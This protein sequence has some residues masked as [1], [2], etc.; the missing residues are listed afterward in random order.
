M[1]TVGK[2]VRSRRVD[3]ASALM[4]AGVLLLGL[5][6]VFAY[7]F[8][9]SYPGVDYDNR[10]NVLA[11]DNACQTNPDWCAVR[12]NLQ[13]GDQLIA[14]GDLTHQ[15]YQKD[16]TRVP[17]AGYGPGDTV[18]IVF[19]RDGIVQYTRWQ[20][21]GPTG[22]V[23]LYRLLNSL[24]FFLP[25]WLA[26]TAV[27]LFLR[28][29]DTRWW[30]LIAF[31]YVTAL[32]LT[33]GASST[34]QVA[35]S[36]LVMHALAWLMVPVYL[37]LHHLLVLTAP[38]PRRR[39]NLFLSFY[40]L[41]A[42]LAALELLQLLPSSAYYLGLLLA[43]AGSFGLLIFHSSSRVPSSGRLAARLILTGVGLAFGP[44]LMLW[45]IPSL[46]HVRA[47]ERIPIT[48][49]TV[50][51][52]L[53]PFFY[54]YALYKHRLGGLEFRANRV[55]SLYSFLVIFG[56]TFVAAFMIGSQWVEF[57]TGELAFALVL[58]VLFVVAAV[59]LQAPYQRLID[60]LAYGTVHNPEDIV[61]TFANEIP[62]ALNYT[63]LTRLLIQEVA[64][65]LLVQQ[66]ALCLLTDD[67]ASLLYA[68]NV[69]IDERP[70]LARHLRQML[71]E[72]GRYRPEEPGAQGLFDWVR[73]PI[74]I[75][76]RGKAIGLWLLGER[77]PDD[78]YPKPDIELLA[79]LGNQIGVALENTRLFE[80]L[81]HR[82]T[83]LEIAYRELQE[84]DQL[85]DEFVQSVSHE[86]RTP[87]TLV[88]G[89]AELL[90]EGDLGDVT[91]EQ[92]R[93]LETIA[94]WTQAAIRRVN[95]V[96][97]IQQA[98]L[99]R[100]DFE[101]VNLAALLRSCV[102]AAEM[103]SRRQKADETVVYTFELDVAENVPAVR[104]D[105]GRM[106][107]VFDN[108][109]NNAV[110]FSPAGGAIKVQVRPCHYRFEATPQDSQPDLAVEVA[111]R[112]QGIGISA[113]HIGRIWD[114]FYQV[115]SSTTRRFGG[116]GLGLTITKSIVKTHGGA[117]RVESQVGVGSTFYVVL[118]VASPSPN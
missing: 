108:L 79:T 117:I 31:N 99:E 46:L 13:V 110:K 25:F 52:P 105:R 54:I 41:A 32:W 87:L 67:L 85:K 36:S 59:L 80:N 113:E 88:Q 75:A 23:R 78:Y 58:S 35:G 10:W 16:R 12:D 71:A 68:D 107:Q 103:I 118:P 17:F 53:L 21:L 100:V 70:D 11:F 98:T 8:L 114:R 102:E 6:Y 4:A 76:V 74:A 112:D 1:S 42:I 20:M 44:A 15:D 57:S 92:K 89:F 48:I 27:L 72:A 63:D 83:E 62:R 38:A 33:A 97:S 28:P 3:N 115:D 101:Q 34:T 26:G 82:A 47:G 104:A 84:L 40:I 64:P 5:T 51:V 73:L 29:R 106:R 22:P 45:V 116:M 50:T 43:L 18:P 91:P 55:L 7:V 2:L 9:A 49:A 111:V 96:L 69:T 65:S 109:L 86:L 90:R 66:S 93:A 81:Q 77:D 95:D 30:L 37:H 24:I 14:I 39:R 19:I 94:D 61:Q 56:T 60:R